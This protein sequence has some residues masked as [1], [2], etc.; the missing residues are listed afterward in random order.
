MG[1]TDANS[2]RRDERRLFD[3]ALCLGILGMVSTLWMTTKKKGAEAPLFSQPR[4]ESARRLLLRGNLG[5]FRVEAAQAV[6]RRSLIRC[7]IDRHLVLG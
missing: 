5:H 3:A 7:R 6:D 1:R 4:I 2:A